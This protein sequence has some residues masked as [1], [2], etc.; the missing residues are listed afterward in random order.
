MYL[1]SPIIGTTTESLVEYIQ[2]VVYSSNL[3]L[4]ITI[5]EDYR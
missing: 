3:Y 5:L 1:P 2:D 4:V